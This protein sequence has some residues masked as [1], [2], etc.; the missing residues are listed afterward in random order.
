LSALTERLD[1][2]G[3]GSTFVELSGDSLAGIS[4]VVPPTATQEAIA[5]YLD[6]ETARIDALISAKRRMVELLEE[7]WVA[8]RRRLTRVGESPSEWG[9]VQLRRIARLQAGAAFPHENQGDDSGTIPYVKVGDLASVDKDDRLMGASNRVSPVVATALRSP[10]LPSGTIVL[11]KI[12]AALLTNRRALLSEPSCLDQN[13]LGVTVYAGQSRFVYYCLSSIDLGNL[14]TP[15]PVPLLNEETALSVRIPWPQI[16]E[17]NAVVR[18]LDAHRAEAK[19][20]LDVIV[21]Q[22][23]LLQERRQALITAAV[24]GQLDIAEAA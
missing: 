8:V 3:Q 24:T 4:L 2:W 5:N 9:S 6:C 20:P 17:Q 21:R 14:S 19:T 15:G 7:R 1:A 18:A 10:I 12:G 23:D 11:P 22:L 16:K 13:V